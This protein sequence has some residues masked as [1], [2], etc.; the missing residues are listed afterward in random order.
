MRNSTADHL[1][2][3]SSRVQTPLQPCRDVPR[4]MVGKGHV[5][6]GSTAIFP[7]PESEQCFAI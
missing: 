4:T 2:P 6:V 5:L 7:I 1:H 3:R